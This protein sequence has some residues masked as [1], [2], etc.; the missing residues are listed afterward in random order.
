MMTFDGTLKEI[1][2]EGLLKS[3]EWYQ[4][5]N[6]SYLI[7]IFDQVGFKDEEGDKISY[8]VLPVSLTPKIKY[9][10]QGKG[11][12]LKEVK[13]VVLSEIQDIYDGLSEK[14]LSSLSVNQ[15]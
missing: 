5:E 13:K 12:K 1:F 6:S 15:L 14:Y 3:K 9:P 7:S 8:F 2:I 10:V 4:S 11:E